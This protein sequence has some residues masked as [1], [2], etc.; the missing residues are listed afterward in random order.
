MPHSFN[1][2][3]PFSQGKTFLFHQLFLV[4]E[5]PEKPA[6]EIASMYHKLETIIVPMFYGRPEAYAE[7]MRLSIALNG[8]FFNTQRMLSQYVLDAYFSGRQSTPLEQVV[9]ETRHNEAA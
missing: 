7:V 5:I 3:H 2:S 6:D 9:A 8:A 4:E 1:R